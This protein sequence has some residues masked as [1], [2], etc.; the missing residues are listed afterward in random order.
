MPEMDGYQFIQRV[1]GMGVSADSLPAVA[2]TAFARAEDRHRAL[3]AGYQNH[4]PKPVAP[5]QLL[6]IVASLAHRNGPSVQGS[7][8]GGG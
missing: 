6:A 7:A 8:G 5:A 4:L 1:R 2:V 3:L